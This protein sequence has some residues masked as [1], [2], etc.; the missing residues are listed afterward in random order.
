[1]LHILEL[2]IRIFFT[3]THNTIYRSCNKRILAMRI[4]TLG[5]KLR[6]LDTIYNFFLFLRIRIVR[7][8]VAVEYIAY[9]VGS[10]IIRFFCS[11]I[12]C[13]VFYIRRKIINHL[14]YYNLTSE[15]K[16]NVRISFKIILQCY[17][18]TDRSW[19]LTFFLSGFFII[20]ILRIS[21]R[22]IILPLEFTLLP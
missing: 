13:D 22:I 12:T 10:S 20:K 5:S 3:E 6:S 2:L 4:S 16:T 21:C 11:G 15:C 8:S 9:F 17:G 18:L 1:M 19:I 7:V 14:I